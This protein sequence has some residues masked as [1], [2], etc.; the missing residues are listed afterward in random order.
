[1][2]AQVPTLN[3][4]F[5]TDEFQN[6]IHAHYR[7]LIKN[8]PVFRNN[9]GVVYVTRYEHCLKLLGGKQFKRNAPQGVGL[10]SKPD[11]ETSLMEQTVS[12]WMLLMDQPRHDVV[13]KAF[14]LPFMPM[15]VEALEPFIIKRSQELLQKI[16][17]QGEVELLKNFSYQLPV[18]VIA[19][20]LGV[21][22][23]DMDLFY[24]WSAKLTAAIDSYTHEG[25]QTGT[26][27]IKQMIEYFDGLLARAETLPP[28]S[29]IRMLHNDPMQLTAAEL[30]SGLIFLLWSGHETT[31]NLIANGIQLMAEHQDIYQELRQ[32]PELIVPFVEEILRLN[33]PVQKS[34]RWVHED[35]VFGD[36]TIPPGT[37]MTALLGAAH[38]DET[39]FKDPGSF[40]IHREDNRHIAFGVGLHRCMGSTLA[41]LE[42]QVAFK[43]FI[44]LV[45]EVRPVRH[46]WRTLSAFRSLD[47]LVVKIIPA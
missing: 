14:T 26:E 20:I 45:K 15:A 10:V 39:V 47:E 41:R 42:G 43:A 31:K 30:N 27:V 9:E 22:P 40:N 33:S 3:P 4:R 36:F 13:R 44:S 37:M 23:D 11:Q 28:H 6:N 25:M 5:D 1:M 7:D 38:Q 29:L 21:P 19:E 8:T 18:M 16:S 17:L 32:K 24:Q 46:R 34:S 12:R 2:P 35:A